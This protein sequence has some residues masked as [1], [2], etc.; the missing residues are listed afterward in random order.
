MRKLAVSPQRTTDENH[1][2]K[3]TDETMKR[4]TMAFHIML[5]CLKI[6]EFI[7]MV[8]VI[9]LMMSG[10]YQ[11]DDKVTLQIPTLCCLA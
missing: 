8:G 1:K 4:C 9:L 10:C 7:L 11:F 5:L 6:F 3:T 2:N